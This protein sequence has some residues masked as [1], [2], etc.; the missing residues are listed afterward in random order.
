MLNKEELKAVIAKLTE[1]LGDL[2]DIKTCSK[3]SRP[4]A[5]RDLCNKHYGQWRREYCRERQI[6][7]LRDQPKI[8]EPDPRQVPLFNAERPTGIYILEKFEF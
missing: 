8:A 3:C 4:A 5:A 1:I 2:E 6:K 7:K